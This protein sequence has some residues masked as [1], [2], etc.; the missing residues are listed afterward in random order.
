LP[1]EFSVL[2]DPTKVA[3]LAG[4]ELAD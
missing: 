3:K 4:M 1:S 2:P